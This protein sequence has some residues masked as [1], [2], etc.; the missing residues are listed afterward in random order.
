MSYKR[1][2]TACF[3]VAVLAFFL[4]S[5][6]S[7]KNLQGLNDKE[8]DPLV[9]TIFYYKTLRLSYLLETPVDYLITNKLYKVVDDWLNLPYQPS[10]D[11][12]IEDGKLVKEIYNKV[13]NYK[14]P[15]TYN[16]LVYNKVFS[17]FTGKS[18]LEEGDLVFFEYPQIDK[19]GEKAEPEQFVGIYLVNNRFLI[20]CKRT[21]K[22]SIE[23]MDDAFWST[24]FK[25][26]GRY[27]TSAKPN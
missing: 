4:S 26:A 10:S 25:F 7:K 11:V 15:G 16:E 17:L 24:Y 9:D 5:C 27:K 20:N 13:Y 6:L 14:I 23:K 3:S 19:S 8:K 21:A 18:F 2:L 1:I 22:V 12:G